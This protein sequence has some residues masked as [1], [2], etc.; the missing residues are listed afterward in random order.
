MARILH[1]EDDFM[2]RILVAE[3]IKRKGG[4]EVISC[5]TLSEAQEVEAAQKFDLVICDGTIGGKADKDNGLHWAR[6]LYDQGKKVVVLTNEPLVP[7]F[8][9]NTSEIEKIL[10]FLK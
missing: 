4:H 7:C 10:E 9:K 2:W 1:V 3:T 5:A 6:V 8:S